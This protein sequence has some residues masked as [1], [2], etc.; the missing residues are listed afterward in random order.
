M[1]SIKEIPHG[2]LVQTILMQYFT[3]TLFAGDSWF[4]QADK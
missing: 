3:D 4:Y 2:H 1:N